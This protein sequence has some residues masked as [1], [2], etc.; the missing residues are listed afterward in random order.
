MKKWRA[1]HPLSAR[2]TAPAPAASAVSTCVLRQI[3]SH[4]WATIDASL[5]RK[6]QPLCRRRPTAWDTNWQ[7]VHPMGPKLDRSSSFIQVVSCAVAAAVTAAVSRRLML[8]LLWKIGP[9]SHF[10]LCTLSSVSL[11][12]HA[13]DQLETNWGCRSPA[14]LG[15]NTH[16]A[17][18]MN[19]SLGE[20]VF[21]LKHDQREHTQSGPLTH[22]HWCAAVA[23]ARCIAGSSGTLPEIRGYRSTCSI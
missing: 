5:G 2:A 1:Q 4:Q 22:V 16:T 21:Q 7:R 12:R 11:A 23:A 9:L 19:K 13:A 6:R 8:R 18:Q 10:S 3:R 14:S 17:H 20:R 15:T